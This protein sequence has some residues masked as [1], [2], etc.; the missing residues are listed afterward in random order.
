MAE[1]NPALL[2]HITAEI[3]L[4]SKPQVTSNKN[5]CA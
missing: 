4:I 1:L 3:A 5:I 2:A